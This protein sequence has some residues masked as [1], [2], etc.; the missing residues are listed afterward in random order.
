VLKGEW[1]VEAGHG[2]I[3]FNFPCNGSL[4][5]R[6]LYKEVELEGILVQKAFESCLGCGVEREF[7]FQEGD[8]LSAKSACRPL[9][10]NTNNHQ[11]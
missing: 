6:V 7:R 9:G 8:L 5:W 4:G 1:L 11:Q 2:D 10:S 3:F